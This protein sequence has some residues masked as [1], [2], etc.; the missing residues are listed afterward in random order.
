MSGNPKGHNEEAFW[1]GLGP[2]EVY[3]DCGHPPDRAKQWVEEFGDHDSCPVCGT[4]C[5]SLFVDD[6]SVAMPA[7]IQFL[8]GLLRS[9]AIAGEKL[10]ELH[11]PTIARLARSGLPATEPTMSLAKEGE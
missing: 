4:D 7:R 11:G 5:Q 8:E 1:A 9:I 10:P 6:V 3:P 2:E